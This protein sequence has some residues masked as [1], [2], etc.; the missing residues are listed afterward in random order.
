MRKEDIATPIIIP[1]SEIE[2]VESFFGKATT[3]TWEGI[4]VDEKFEG[5]LVGWILGTQEDFVVYI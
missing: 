1:K 2:D 4:N 5:M 3:T